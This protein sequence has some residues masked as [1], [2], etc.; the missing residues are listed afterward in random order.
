MRYTSLESLHYLID[1]IKNLF[2][3]KKGGTLESYTEK[4]YN[5]GA[6]DILNLLEGNVFSKNVTA[7][8]TFTIANAKPN[9]SHS[10]TLYLNM[11][12]TLRTVSYPASV[13]WQ[14]G[15]VPVLVANKMYIMT[16]ST[17]DGGTTWYGNWGEY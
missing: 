9:V 14:D 10:F 5:I 17:I 16:F 3:Q 1:T 12:A 13:K 7:D 6:T 11:G 8:T 4:V 15:E 2:L